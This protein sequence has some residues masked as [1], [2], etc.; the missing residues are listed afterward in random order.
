M[1]TT[2]TIALLPLFM[3]L[4]DRVLPGL[5]GELVPFAGAV[6]DAL[7]AAGAGVEQAPVCA[8]HSEIESAIEALRPSD[9]DL[10][11]ILHLT[12]SPSLEAVPAL[13]AAPWPILFFDTS[14]DAGFPRETNPLRMLQ[15][16]GIHGVQDLAC[17][18]RRRG[19]AFE[20]VAGHWSNADVL[21]KVVGRARAGA[22]VR[23][24]R[25]MKTICIGGP[26]EG[27]GDF[28]VED[29][30]L[31]RALGISPRTIAPEGLARFIECVTDSEIEQERELDLGRYRVEVDAAVHRRSL[32]V[33]LGLRRLLEEEGCGAFSLNFD[34]FQSDRPPVDT[35]PFLECCKAMERGT[36]YAGEGDMLTASFVGALSRGWDRV[37][38][39][40]MFCADWSGNTLFFSHMAEFNPQLA[41]GPP[42]L[43]EKEYTLSSAKNPAALA[44][45][46]RP[47]PAVLANLSPGPDESFRMLLAPVEILGDGTH[48]DI[49]RWVR[50]WV[51]PPIP[52]ASF[53]EHYSLLGG[54]HHLALAV[55]DRLDDLTAFA[56]MAGIEARIIQ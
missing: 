17:M 8:T 7:R 11:V 28:V 39:A 25:S 37:S 44:M 52:V 10:L 30:V 46:P 21:R 32:R 24:L 38:F 23:A 12:Y 43:Y 48:P 3:D 40:E 22:A 53:L 31:V 36:G 29:E 55:G 33:G 49:G 20:I 27:M 41:D 18:L 15:N 9:P 16:H 35:V 14:P 45:A 5:R 54:S 47:G 6:A 26:L 34:A 42:L 4:Y 56:R 50:A 13:C 2:P 1:H 51:R 19:R